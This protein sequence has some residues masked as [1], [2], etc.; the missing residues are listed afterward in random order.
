M[1]AI[2]NDQLRDWFK[3]SRG[4]RQGDPLSPFLFILLVDTLDR[5]F[6]H[7]H[8]RGVNKGFHVGREEEEISHLQ[9]ANDTLLLLE[10]SLV[11]F[12]K[13]ILL[14]KIF[15]KILGLK[16]NLSKSGIAGINMGGR[17]LHI[18]N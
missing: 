14:L 11:K 1:P 12:K 18:S 6:F 10:N 15:E 13:A 16:I 9:F 17:T 4:L 2:L 8:A 3:A 5:L 7:A